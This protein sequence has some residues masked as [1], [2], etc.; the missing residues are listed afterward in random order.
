M[1]GSGLSAAILILAGELAAVNAAAAVG[2]DIYIDPAGWRARLGN[3]EPD[4][5]DWII[6]TADESSCGPGSAV[7]IRIIHDDP[8]GFWLWCDVK[9][10]EG[11]G[12]EV[13]RITRFRV[14]LADGRALESSRI[15]A[16]GDPC[17]S[18]TNLLDNA[19]TPFLITEAA[20][21]GYEDEESGIRWPRIYVRFAD[22][23]AIEDLES[24]R[25]VGARLLCVPDRGPSRADPQLAAPTGGDVE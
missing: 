15:I 1:M 17:G 20:V 23:F 4:R 5:I 18:E 6:K 12:I 8:L 19:R 16:S 21:H 14:F 7:Q 9:G 10:L 2:G 24:W 11:R 3:V 13:G 22:R 25:P